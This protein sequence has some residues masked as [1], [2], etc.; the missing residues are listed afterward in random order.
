MKRSILI[1]KIPTMFMLS[2]LFVPMTG[3]HAQDA[4]Q[5]MDMTELAKK[6]Q[7][8]V[9]SMI[10]IPLGYYGNINW[11]PEKQFASTLELKPVVPIKLSSGLNL[12]VRSIIPVVFLP[13]PVNR[14]GLSDIQLQF[15]FAPSKAKKFI[16]GIGPMVSFPTGLPYE[17]C[18]GKWTAGPI[19]VGL[20][21]LK[22]WVVGA[23]VNQRWSFAGD[24]SMPDV[25][26]L[27]INAFANYNFKHGW[28]ISYAPEIYA[29]W[30]QPSAQV[31][32]VPV[33]LAGIKAFH[34]GK[35][36]MS[37]NLGYY[38]NA[39]RPSDAPEMYIKAAI[40]LLFLK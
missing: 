32:T 11:G 38:F 19:G 5:K 27:Y 40:S 6:T 14:S 1:R 23:L 39:I 3:L 8:P 35:Q 13:S 12:I 17:M 22:H 20:F 7:N 29:N 30:N 25:N 37:A 34:I 9:E 16:W 2:I 33:G 31:W 28:A 18:S 4:G 24:G 36:M 15:Y 10:Q 21:M 26:Q